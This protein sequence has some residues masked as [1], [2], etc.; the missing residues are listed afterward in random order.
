LRPSRD[1]G[2][3]A[4]RPDL[5]VAMTRTEIL[6]ALRERLGAGIWQLAAELEKTLKGLHSVEHFDLTSP[7]AVGAAIHSA[8]PQAAMASKLE[9]CGLKAVRVEEGP[10]Y[11]IVGTIELG[12]LEREV[13]LELHYAGPK[14]GVRKP[15]HQFVDIEDEAAPS[16]PGFEGLAPKQILMFLGYCLAKSR[17]S[18]DKLFLAYADKVDRQ[19]V[20]IPRPALVI[21]EP[22]IEGADALFDRATKVRGTEIKV[23]K[24]RKG[25]EKDAGSQVK[26]G[27]GSSGA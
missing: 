11:K 24:A 5:E 4:F 10:A 2:E 7:A 22:K 6:T 16:L 18:I 15:Q 14:G 21:P 1:S 13:N 17:V 26:R 19:K 9:E 23:K 8:I 20:A 3:F 27:D 25:T 12:G